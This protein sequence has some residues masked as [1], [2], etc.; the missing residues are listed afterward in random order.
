MA[1]PIT[2]ARVRAATAAPARPVRR[3][4]VAKQAA[5][6]RRAYAATVL[7]GLARTQQGQPVARVR[8]L[9]RDALTPLG[10][11]LPPT[12]WQQLASDLATG[13]PVTLP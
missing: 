3:P 9:V 2:A 7:R 13:R 5:A 4:A 1:A 6:H 11:R 10:I 8:K 12:G